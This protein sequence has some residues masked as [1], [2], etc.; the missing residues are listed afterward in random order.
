VQ[1]CLIPI[2][3]SPLDVWTV[4]PVCAESLP[5]CTSTHEPDGLIRP[6]QVGWARSYP[7]FTEFWRAHCSK[8]AFRYSKRRR[9]KSARNA[10]PVRFSR[11]RENRSWPVPEGGAVRQN[12]DEAIVPDRFY[13]IRENLS[14]PVPEGGAVLPNSAEPLVAA[15]EGDAHRNF[16]RILQKLPCRSPREKRPGCPRTGDAPLTIH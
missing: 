8:S 13:R 9:P 2:E 12:S 3:N 14:W 5:D 4:R 11:I 1:I 6:T 16:C 7:S 15:P 10:R